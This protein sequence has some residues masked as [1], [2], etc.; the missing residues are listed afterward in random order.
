MQAEKLAA[1]FLVRRMP[2][3]LWTRFKQVLRTLPVLVPGGRTGSP[4]GTG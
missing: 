4:Q 1:P 2:S 3:D